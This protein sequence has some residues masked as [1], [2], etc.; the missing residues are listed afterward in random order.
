MAH[1]KDQQVIPLRIV[2]H[3]PVPG[4]ELRLQSGRDALVDPA[5]VSD[6]SVT[7]DL[8]VRVQL[9][10]ADGLVGFFGPFTQGP[11]R[12]RFVYVNAGR[13]AGQPGSCWDRR[14][15]IPLTGIS[16]AL[17]RR[18]LATPGSVLE[19]AVPGRSRDG[20]PVC[21]SVKL[22]PDA[23]QLRPPATT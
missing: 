17:V 9:P 21:A 7:F 20:G 6:A 19:V 8:T 18:Q 12:A 13:H 3:D 22:P 1:R 5:G 11:P 10:D 14:A 4:V 16:P 15:K 2:M 23:W